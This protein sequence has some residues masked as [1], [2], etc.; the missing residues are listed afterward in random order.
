MGMRIAGL[1]H[2]L[3]DPMAGIPNRVWPLSS[4]LSWYCEWDWLEEAAAGTLGHAPP[5]R[6]RLHWRLLVGVDGPAVTLGAFNH[7]GAVSPTKK[8]AGS[9]GKSGSSPNSSSALKWI[10]FL[11]FSSFSWEMSHHHALSLDSWDFGSSLR[12]SMEW[13]SHS[14]AGWDHGRLEERDQHWLEHEGEGPWCHL[15]PPLSPEQVVLLSDRDCLCWCLTSGAW[16]SSSRPWECL[17]PLE[18]NS[19]GPISP[20]KPAQVR[21]P[22]RSLHN[23]CMRSS[24]CTWVNMLDTTTYSPL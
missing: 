12:V 9:E 7:S 24:C 8:W 18:D 15:N 19:A 23:S 6:E 17:W 21:C 2:L 4:S 10:C 5:A 13:W 22:G 11:G 20:C 3:C 1:G 14:S 16:F